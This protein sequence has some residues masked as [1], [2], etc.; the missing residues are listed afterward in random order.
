MFLHGAGSSADTWTNLIEY[1]VTSG[2]EVIAP[3]MLGHGFSSAPDS[4]KAYT[5]ACL[6]QDA[7]QIF[8]TYI[9]GD[10]KCVLIAH[11]YG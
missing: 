11:G 3:D 2:Y 8:D 5:F 10:K 4:K 6:L 1:F 9:T 7:L